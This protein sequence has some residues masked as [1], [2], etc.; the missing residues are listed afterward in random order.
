MGVKTDLAIG[1]GIVVAGGAI[2]IKLYPLLSSSLN[3]IRSS[4]ARATQAASVATDSSLQAGLNEWENPSCTDPTDPNCVKR[5]STQH[6]VVDED[7]NHV[8]WSNH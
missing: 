8:G 4:V 2:A 3:A 7:G 6:E 5:T 1:T